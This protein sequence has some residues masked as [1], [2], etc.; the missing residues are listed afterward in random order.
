MYPATPEFLENVEAEIRHQVERLAHHASLALWCGNNEDLG[1]IT[2]YEESRANR[3]R[4]VI[5]Y[6]RLNE[7]VVGRVI[8]EQD[9]N[10]TWW[11]SSPSAGVGDFSDNWTCDKRGDM[12]F[13][14]VWRQQPSRVLHHHPTLC[15]RVRLPVLSIAL[16]GEELCR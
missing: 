2:W 10:R 6:D 13:W 9:P 4:Y 14:S 12:H 5:D 7:G 16:D 3:D 1:A 11:P 15:Q 8:Q